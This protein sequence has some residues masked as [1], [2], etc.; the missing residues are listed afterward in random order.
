MP[1]N[2]VNPSERKPEACESA[3]SRS[4]LSAATKMFIAFTA[5]LRIADGYRDPMP[6]QMRLS[7][8]IACTVM[9]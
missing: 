2:L 9:S 7:S 5:R 4:R 6:H 3:R 8:P 1:K